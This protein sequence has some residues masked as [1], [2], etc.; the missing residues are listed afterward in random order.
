LILLVLCEIA[1]T[2]SELL[3]TF[4]MFLSVVI[5][6]KFSNLFSIGEYT[7]C[8]QVIYNLLRVSIIFGILVQ[9]FSVQ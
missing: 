2:A 9:S 1:L 6:S 7:E 5:S 4:C 8:A 3:I